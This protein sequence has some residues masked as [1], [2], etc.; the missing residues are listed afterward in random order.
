MEQGPVLESLG[1]PLGVVEGIA[2]QTRLRVYNLLSCIGCFS[3][4]LERAKKLKA[5]PT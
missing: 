1:V 5:N 2:G 4:S 3:H